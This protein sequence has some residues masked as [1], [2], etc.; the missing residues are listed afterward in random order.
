MQTVMACCG[1]LFN[2]RTW[3]AVVWYWLHLA[4][5]LLPDSGMQKPPVHK[6]DRNLPECCMQDWFVAIRQGNDM[7]WLLKQDFP[8]TF[9]PRNKTTRL[10]TKLR[11]TG[12][13]PVSSRT[14]REFRHFLHEMSWAD[15]PQELGAVAAIRKV[16]RCGS[17]RDQ[18]RTLS[19][20]LGNLALCWPFGDEI[21]WRSWIHL[22]LSRWWLCQ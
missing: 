1:L 3:V 15:T 5:D 19:E 13:C 11:Q 14:T 21:F 6:L 17:Y 18:T 7:R 22:N 9:L 20:V 12:L 10:H 16:Q 2:L 8:C 4:V